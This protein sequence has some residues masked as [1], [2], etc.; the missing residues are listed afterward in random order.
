MYTAGNGKAAICSICCVSGFTDLSERTV[1][2]G[3]DVQ[4]DRIEAEIAS[5]D[6]SKLISEWSVTV[7]S[8]KVHFIRIKNGAKTENY[9]PVSISKAAV[10]ATA[11]VNGLRPPRD[12]YQCDIPTD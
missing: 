10:Y 4:K 1:T 7:F 9:A 2:M 12:L 5:H 6:D 3:V 11:I 8:D